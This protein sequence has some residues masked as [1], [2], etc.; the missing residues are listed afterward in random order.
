MLGFV[1]DIHRPLHNK[2]VGLLGL[3]AMILGFT[4][5]LRQNGL[6]AAGIFV[7]AS[8]LALFILLSEISCV[9]SG[10][11]H[12]TAILNTI[13]ASIIFMSVI[14]YYA[15]DGSHGL[16]AVKD[17]PIAKVDRAIIPVS[18]LVEDG[19]KGFIQR[20]AMDHVN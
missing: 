16:P 17:Q 13:I 20:R 4:A 14:W 6:A 2:I 10:K 15:T 18:G 3:I 1:K 11:C 8:A 9:L 19:V 7:A 5:N 12:A